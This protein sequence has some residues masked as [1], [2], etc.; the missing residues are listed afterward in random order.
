MFQ[1]STP[2]QHGRIRAKKGEKKGKRK[3]KKKKR[4]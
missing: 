2:Y 1:K 4:I 3:K